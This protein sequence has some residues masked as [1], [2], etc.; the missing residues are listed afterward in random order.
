MRIQQSVNIFLM[1]KSGSL[2]NLDQGGYDLGQLGFELAAV[3]P[4]S[5]V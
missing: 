2:G 5:T 3:P 1:D 4:T